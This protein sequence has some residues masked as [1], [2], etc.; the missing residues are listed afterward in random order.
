[1]QILVLQGDSWR[2]S[3]SITSCIKGYM[4]HGKTFLI[5]SGLYG[6]AL[7]IVFGAAGGF[8]GGAIV[9]IKYN[10]VPGAAHGIRMDLETGT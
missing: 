5:G 8:I 2:D 9:T 6:F 10:R 1:L 3:F 4:T 7:M